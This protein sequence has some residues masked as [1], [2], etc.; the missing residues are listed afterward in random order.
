LYLRNFGHIYKEERVGIMRK[1]FIDHGN[2]PPDLPPKIYGLREPLMK[3]FSVPKKNS[4][5]T[6]D[7]NNAISNLTFQDDK[8]RGTVQKKDFL[9]VVG[10]GAQYH[11]VIND[12]YIGY[13]Q[14][15]RFILFNYKDNSFRK[16]V[17]T[18][19]GDEY[20]SR[21]EVLDWEKRLFVFEVLQTCEHYYKKF[22]RIFFLKGE[23]QRLIKEGEFGTTLNLSYKWQVYKKFIFFHHGKN[24]EAYDAHLN[25]ITHPLVKF[26]N[27]NKK[28][29]IMIREFVIH[30]Y[31]PFAVI[32]DDLFPRNT[33]KGWN[34]KLWVVRWEHPDEEE[35]LIPFFP[36]NKSII[37]PSLKELFIVYI[38]FSP[39]GKWLVLYDQSDWRNSD[40][41]VAIPVE[42]NNPKYFGKPKLLGK[43]YYNSAE[44]STAWIA[45]PT[46]FV[47]CY[48]ETL[49]KWDLERLNDPDVDEVDNPE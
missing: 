5:A 48:G 46:S 6:N 2:Y 34:N 26:I 22:I 49:Y 24:V 42:P 41:F 3:I 17:I 19:D 36:Y 7:I 10:G 25:K 9:E 44:Y 33:G 31:L 43:N 45:D 27:E 11:T 12:E 14:E 35:V 21:V 8:I 4:V 29:F 39:D 20:V 1:K 47:A 37:K 40:S 16:Y 38:Q 28:K 30:P 23:E 15:R 13:S 32:M 18:T